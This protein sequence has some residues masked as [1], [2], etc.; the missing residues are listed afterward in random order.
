VSSIF[1][2]FSAVSVV[3]VGLVCLWVPSGYATPGI[4]EA[5]APRKGIFL[6]ASSEMS[7]PR[8]QQ[9]VIVLLS[10][11]ENGALGLIVNRPTNIDLAEA[12]PDLG[13]GGGK[14][15]RLYF[16]GPVAM[17]RILFLVRSEVALGRADYIMD[18]VYGSAD[19]IVLE[20][21][22]NLKKPGN[23]LHIYFGYAGWGRGQ[24]E[25]EIGE[26]SWHLFKADAAMIFD[27]EPNTLWRR[28]MERRR[29]GQIVLWRH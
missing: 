27:D 10:H 8:F 11:D 3:V 18:D 12:L 1:I 22:L 25:A 14:Q 4:E 29:T 6:V 15:H 16:G 17:E 24:L 23:A 13:D 7:D 26:R 2:S 20:Q 21:L 19:R 5:D 28:F 9:A